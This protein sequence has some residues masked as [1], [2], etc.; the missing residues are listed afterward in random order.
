MRSNANE[1]FL[2]EKSTN[3]KRKLQDTSILVNNEDE[4]ANSILKEN[5]FNSSKQVKLSSQNVI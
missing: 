2:N 1:S 5:N 3:N 4:L